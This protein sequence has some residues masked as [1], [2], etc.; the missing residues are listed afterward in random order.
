MEKDRFIALIKERGFENIHQ[1][2][3]ACGVESA[4]IYTNLSG[5]NTMG[6]KR[7]FLYA[8]T[9]GVSIDEILKIFLPEQ[10]ENNR[11]VCNSSDS[12]QHIE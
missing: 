6:I 7:A 4:N 12:R 1:F 11:R 2:S 5:R 10:M 9:L 8:D 3:K